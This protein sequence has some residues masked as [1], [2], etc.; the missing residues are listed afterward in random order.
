MT[1][2]LTQA[3]RRVARLAAQGHTNR[4]IAELLFLS[5][6]TVAWHLRHVYR[7]LG[8][9]RNGLAEALKRNAA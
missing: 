8:V 2:H 7:K 9:T 6:K 3:E 1:D 4:E 5:Q